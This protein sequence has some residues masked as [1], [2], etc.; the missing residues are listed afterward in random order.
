MTGTERMNVERLDLMEGSARSLFSMLAA[1]SS[2]DSSLCHGR[3]PSDEILVELF[4]G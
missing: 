3:P 1:S 2:S 4:V